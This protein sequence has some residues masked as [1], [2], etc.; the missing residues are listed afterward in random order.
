MCN[1]V[2]KAVN[3]DCAAGL[4]QVYVYYKMMSKPIAKRVFSAAAHDPVGTLGHGQD[5]TQFISS[6]C[7]KPGTNTLLAANSQGTIKLLQLAS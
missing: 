1:N 7:W 3:T 5:G 6:L 4:V 2:W